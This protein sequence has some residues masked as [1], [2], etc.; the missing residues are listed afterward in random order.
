M[1]DHTHSM[2]ESIIIS[3][4][5]VFNVHI[6]S[7]FAHWSGPAIENFGGVFGTNNQ[8]L[9]FLRRLSS[10]LTYSLVNDKWIKISSP[11]DSIDWGAIYYNEGD[12]SYW[13]G[14]FGQLIHFDK[15]FRILKKYTVAD[16]LKPE[17]IMGIVPDKPG[18]I[19][20]QFIRSIVKINIPKWKNI[21]FI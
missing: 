12:K 6:D 21:C 13:V 2:M 9:I 20:I 7:P 3:N 14:S 18:N 4:Q 11:I 17:D 16:G 15:D 19:W 5:G 8:N 1:T 10:N